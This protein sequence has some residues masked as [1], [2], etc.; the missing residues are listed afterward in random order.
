MG[1]L[2]HRT[3]I[4]SL[5]LASSVGLA[6]F[7]G[8]CSST[9]NPPPN[10]GSSSSSSSSGSSS[11]GVVEDSGVL[12]DGGGVTIEDGVQVLGRVDL[13]AV[14]DMKTKEGARL[15]WP[16][17]QVRIKFKGTELK[18][19]F[20]ETPDV[21]ID[22]PAY[23]TFSQYLV[24]VDG[25]VTKTI[26]LKSGANVDEVL[27]TG[28]E[29]K[30][31][32]V[33]LFRKTEANIGVTTFLGFT[34]ATPLPIE[35][36]SRKI[37]F[38]GDSITVGY[39]AD[40][41]G[42]YDRTYPGDAPSGIPAGPATAECPKQNLAT[43]AEQVDGYKIIIDSTNAQVAYPAVLATTFKAEAAVVAWSGKGLTRNGDTST[44]ETIRTLYPRANA[45]SGSSMWDASKWQADLVIVNIGTNDFAYGQNPADPGAKFA[46]D[47]EELLK[48]VRANYPNALIYSLVGPMLPDFADGAAGGL[49]R[50]QKAITYMK[51][52]ITNLRNAGDMKVRAEPISVTQSLGKVGCYFHPFRETHTTMAEKLADEIRLD[53]KWR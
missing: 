16:G 37:E 38:I 1:Y 40:K 21:S 25:M 41:L 20:R 43:P 34:G 31:H 35:R 4:I 51:Q 15:S 24:I 30:E 28:L 36:P 39:G 29:D 11:G 8:A 18:A 52:A 5:V 45:V 19:S 2:H 3:T 6:A 53:L 14:S 46:A 17:A 26:K 47:Y 44:A 33:S 49:N 48:A 9:E 7:T 22:Q 23:T 13:S 27:A 50:K 12:D 10:A 32:E 42:P